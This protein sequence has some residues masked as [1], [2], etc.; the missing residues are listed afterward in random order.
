M[1]NGGWYTVN[2]WLIMANL[3]LAVANLWLIMV[4]LWLMMVN[5]WLIMVNLWLMVVNLWLMIVNLWLMMVNNGWSW[6]IV[7]FH[8][9][10]YPNSWLVY[11]G[12][13]QSRNG[14]WLGVASFLRKPPAWEKNKKQ[15]LELW[16]IISFY[17]WLFQWDYTFYK[18][19]IAYTWCSINITTNYGHG[20]KI[21]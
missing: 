6:M 13:S 21:H 5:L 16:P 17:N 8:K 4:N 18:Y 10:G 11:N 14:W 1:V 9:W 3:W 19:P 2:L 12:T 7:G 15:P 20:W